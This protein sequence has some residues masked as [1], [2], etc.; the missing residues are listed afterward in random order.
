MSYFNEIKNP[1]TRRDPSGIPG[2][3]S[4]PDWH[5]DSGSGS[6]EMAKNPNR[7]FS[8]GKFPNPIR[9]SPEPDSGMATLLSTLGWHL[10]SEFLNFNQCRV[11]TCPNWFKNEACKI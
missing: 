4:N 3:E 7:E 1:E 8:V 2:R 11:L 10:I 6:R 9:T 5:P